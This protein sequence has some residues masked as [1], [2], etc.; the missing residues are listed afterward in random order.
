MVNDCSIVFSARS[1]VTTLTVRFVHSRTRHKY[2]KWS[3]VE[4]L[5]LIF[6]NNSIQTLLN[7]NQ[8]RRQN[9]SNL[10]QKPNENKNTRHSTSSS[11]HLKTEKVIPSSSSS[12]PH[13]EV[14]SAIPYNADLDLTIAILLTDVKHGMRVAALRTKFVIFNMRGGGLFP[15]E[16]F[17]IF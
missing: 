14:G 11:L 10:I 4:S 5:L 13:P 8:P 1:W 7:I 9:V 17:L 2:T 16:R 15:E 3:F 6:L 12:R